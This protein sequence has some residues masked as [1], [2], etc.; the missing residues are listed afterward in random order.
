MQWQ[1]GYTD[2]AHGYHLVIEYHL[3]QIVYKV[4]GGVSEK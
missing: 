1:I 4:K 2:L 3:E